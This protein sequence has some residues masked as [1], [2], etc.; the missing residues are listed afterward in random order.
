M[1]G[2]S[3][4]SNPRGMI[5]S[6]LFL[7]LGGVTGCFSSSD[8]GTSSPPISS[9]DSSSASPAPNPS[10]DSTA[11]T[12]GN[13]AAPAAEATPG[14]AAASSDGSKAPGT[15]AV[16]ITNVGSLPTTTHG[17]PIIPMMTEVDGIAI[18]RLKASTDSLELKGAIPV[19][20][21]NDHA[22][23]QPGEKTTGDWV[24]IR[25]NSEPKILNSIVETSAV[26][27][28]MGSYVHEALAR[29]DPETFEYLPHI[30]SKWTTEDSV[31]LSPDYPGQERRIALEGGS[32][33]KQLEI[34]YDWPEA[35]DGAERPDPPKLTLSTSDADG[36]PMGKVW[37]GV[38]PIGKIVGASITGYHLWS[39]EAGKVTLAGMPTGRYT[40][41]VG[42]EL[43]G[44]AV[45]GPDRSLTVTPE[46]PENPLHQLIQ[47]AGQT[48]LTLKPGEWSDVQYETYY[49][50]YLRDDV[51]WSDGQPFTTKDLEFAYAVINNLAVDGDSLR[52]YYADLIEC[53]PLSSTV[54]RMRYRQQYFKSF[55]FTAG[56][57]A[58]TPPFHKFS[59]YLASDGLTLTLDR[60][61][62]EQE[63]EKKAISAHGAAFGKF[64]NTDPR[65][66]RSPLGTGPY[67]FGT[68]ERSD[69]VELE[70]NRNYW[71]PER[72]GHL[73]KIIAKFIPDNVTAMQALKAGEIDFFWMLTPEQFF[74][75]LKGPP[76]WF[77]GKYV[78][79]SWFTPMF[80]YF[81]WNELMPTFQDRRV[82]I[83]L[84]LLF[85]KQDFLE[86]K[87]YGQGVVVSGT[88][89]YFGPGYDHTVPPLA[90]DPDVARDLL[91][92][93]GWFDSDNDG[94]LDKDGQP[95]KIRIHL[96]PG[97]PVAINRC[98]LLQKN[99]KSVG[100]ELDVQFLEW[101][102][103]IDKI[104]AKDYDV[105]TLS[106]ATPTESDPYQIW[107][108]SQAGR[109]SRGS[110]HVSFSNPLADQLIEQL[111][112]TL[113]E[114][115]RKEIHAAFHRLLDQEQ[116][117][118]FLY[119]VKDFGV[120]HQRFRGVKWYR[121]RPGFDLSEWWVP[122]AEQLH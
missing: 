70:R 42:A 105:C 14:T 32:P 78:K 113:D 73:D 95:F 96:P 61:T 46:T 93:A 13:P 116:P 50:F 54:I 5:W 38:Y 20:V 66:N 106:W 91:S 12:E 121:L 29:Q 122:K 98:E 10:P 7:L 9:G 23:A 117:Y 26:Q 55:E 97:N 57:G 2:R 102:S 99:L 71:N 76:D 45:E 62:P 88:Q 60:L 103:F 18:P 74:E 52:T 8:P 84:G 92:E 63:A 25:F 17:V 4:R 6:L 43:F 94:L 79:A 44:T 27:Q 69:R 53:L 37:V 33:E 19:D 119:C 16:D 49:T 68:W 77:Q 36:K 87:L 118:M 100:I 112:V 72:G 82:R 56:L 80:N 30:A 15:Y 21:G 89:Y 83:A 64:F 111:R 59:E 85:D 48:S 109:Q 90:Y 35:Q 31:K 41:K 58:Y 115:K 75:D 120:Y 86:K 34:Q 107:H 28:Y 108:G 81:G 1:V 65:Y 39:D 11:T 110:N 101:A 3:L 51:K 67:V 104:K 24:T 47:S 22:Q 40:V 114:S